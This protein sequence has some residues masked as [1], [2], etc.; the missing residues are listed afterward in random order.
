ME[1]PGTCIVLPL[2]TDPADVTLVAVTAQAE[3]ALGGRC[4]VRLTHFPFKVGRESRLSQA[5][6]AREQ[7][8]GC[9]PQLND[10]Y[11]SEPHGAEVI[12]ISRDHF[13]IEHVGGEFFVVDRGSVA[14]TIVAGRRIGGHRKGGRT[15][16][17]PG[18]EIVIGGETSPYVFRLTSS[19]VT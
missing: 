15:R 1:A 5:G 13:A 11:H 19:E 17:H 16:L 7:R 3:F 8:L 14:G 2:E 10:L 6:F 12:H 18:D 4:G 9:T